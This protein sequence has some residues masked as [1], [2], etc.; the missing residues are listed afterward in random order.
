MQIAIFTMVSGIVVGVVGYLLGFIPASWLAINLGLLAWWRWTE[1]SQ[2]RL[3]VLGVIVGVNTLALG[4]VYFVVAFPPIVPALWLICYTALCGSLWILNFQKEVGTERP[5]GTTTSEEVVG[6]ERPDGTTTSEAVQLRGNYIGP[7]EGQFILRPLISAWLG[8]TG[9]SLLIAGINYFPAT[10]Q[11]LEHPFITWIILC[12]ATVV[13]FALGWPN[14]EAFY[15]HR[16]DV[17]AKGEQ[18]FRYMHIPNDYVAILTWL[19]NR[20]PIYLT[21]G[22]QPWLPSFLGFGINRAALYGATSRENTPVGPKDGLVYVGKEVLDIWDSRSNKT[23]EIENVTRGGSTVRATFLVSYIVTDPLAYAQITDPVLRIA[24]QARAGLRKAFAM[25][26]DIDVASMKSVIATLAQ[27]DAALAA[28]TKREMEHLPEGS[29]M[30]DAAGNLFADKKQGG[31]PY[32]DT[33]TLH[34]HVAK[35]AHPRFQGVGDDGEPLFSVAELDLGEKLR[36]VI[37]ATGC[38]MIS[39]VIGN[40]TLSETVAEASRQAE[41]AHQARLATL[42]NAQAQLDARE[43]LDSGPEVDELTR[44]IALINGGAANVQLV[45][46]TGHPLNRAAATHRVTREPKGDDEE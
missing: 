30:T 28:F 17:A 15:Q 42:T 45:H 26:R 34:T 24:D 35:N 16:S 46:T 29:V 18:T 19:G 25:F 43:L 2:M 41:A 10:S 31:T 3:W 37:E 39:A 36:P 21:E 13:A 5:D 7:F 40:I 32:E 27:G 8:L 33:N 44:I 12:G 1:S 23:I 38:E 9:V 20:L 6:T 14:Q 11:V 4:G 22:D